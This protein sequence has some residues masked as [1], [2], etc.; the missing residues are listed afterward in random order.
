MEGVGGDD[1]QHQ[2]VQHGLGQLDGEADDAK[3]VL[4]VG[5]CP[6]TV[7]PPLSPL[8]PPAGSTCLEITTI[9]FTEYHLSSLRQA[10]LLVLDFIDH[11][12]PAT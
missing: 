9:F 2:L 1:Q 4:Y 5:L 7:Y 3:E 6:G 12:K 11:Q 10:S 8:S